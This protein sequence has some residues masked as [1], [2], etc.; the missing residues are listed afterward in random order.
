VI[1][2]LC[3]EVS[4]PLNP[5]MT[6]TTYVLPQEDDEETWGT[7]SITVPPLENILHADTPLV[8]WNILYDVSS[9]G[10]LWYPLK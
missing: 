9:K 5:V 10:H 3:P 4:P 7:S 6:V 8:I 2:Y 1:N